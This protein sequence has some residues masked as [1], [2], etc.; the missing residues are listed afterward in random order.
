MKAHSSQT[1]NSSLLQ[2]KARGN[3]LAASEITLTRNIL[4]EFTRFD[5]RIQSGIPL[6]S[7]QWLKNTILKENSET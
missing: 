3:R 2:S 7:F 4:R 6:H 5:V 1:E